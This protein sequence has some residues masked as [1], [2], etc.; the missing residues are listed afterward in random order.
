MQQAPDEKERLQ[1]LTTIL[2]GATMSADV[3]LGALAVETAALVAQDLVSLARGARHAALQRVIKRS[4]VP[5]STSTFRSR[6]DHRA[7]HHQVEPA[8]KLCLRRT[9][10]HVRGLRT[11]PRRRSIVLLREH[12]CTQDPERL[13]GRRRR[14]CDCQARDFGHGRAAASEAGTFRQRVE[15]AIR[16]PLVWTAWYRKDTLG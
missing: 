14:S 13:L 3:D 4:S 11:S 2:Q 16:H 8:G 5:P 15:E 12:R 6:A 10:P 7:F 9:L 1:M